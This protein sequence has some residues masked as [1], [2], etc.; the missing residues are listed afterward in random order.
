MTLHGIDRQ[1]QT[2][3]SSFLKTQIAG[4]VKIG[5][6]LGFIRRKCILTPL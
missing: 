4:S 3:S 6:H 2:S 5:G 1:L